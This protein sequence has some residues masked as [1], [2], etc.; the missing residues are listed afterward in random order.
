VED[1]GA[2]EDC[3]VFEFSLSD[4]W[5]VVSND[6]EL[7]LAISKLLLSELVTFKRLGKILTYQS[8]TFQT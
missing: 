5:A 8:C 1:L 3:E 7:A 2:A 6:H 4:S